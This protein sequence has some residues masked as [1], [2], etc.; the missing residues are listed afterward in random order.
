[1][2]LHSKTAVTALVFS[3]LSLCPLCL[4]GETVVVDVVSV[5][6]R[7]VER[8]LRLPGD[9]LP[10]E[11]VD[12]HA[13][14]AGFVNVVNVD[15]GSIVKKGQ[16]LVVLSAPELAAQRAEAEAKATGAESQLAEAQAKLASAEATFG[17]LKEAAATP[18]AVAGNE[19]VVAEKTVDAAKAAV[20]AQ[21]NSGTA[22]KA[23]VRAIADLES[24][25]KVS[26]PFDGTVTER[27]VHPGALV[28]PGSG[29]MPL[30]R[31]EHNTR[32]RLVIPVPE[33]ATAGIA[34]GASVP[35]SVP[36]YPGQT[37]SGRVAR[38][39]RSVDPKTRTMPVELEVANANRKLA[40]GMYADVKWPDRRRGPS[41]L[42]PPSAIAV[43][44]ERTFVIRVRDGRAEYVNISRGTPAGDLVEVFG[45]L[46][47]GDEIVRR[48]SDEIREGALLQVRKSSEGKK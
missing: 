4:R 34:T 47:A 43:T 44:T 46:N 23:A 1:M 38:I 32:L 19:L 25:L 28:G 42:V 45:P 27:L 30:L 15:R 3:A 29:A 10:Y 5:I 13:R 9:L 2:S 33:A 11:H 37:F 17:R 7:T 18:G 35:F 48:A 39:S 41:L 22:A 24:Y 26:A 21:E 40:P 6:S 20:R 16:L 8:S 31:I 36:A 12:L 14:V